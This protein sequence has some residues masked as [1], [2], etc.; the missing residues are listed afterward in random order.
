MRCVR[1][2]TRTCAYKIPSG[3][4]NCTNMQQR[5]LRIN[6]RKQQAKKPIGWGWSDCITASAPMKKR[7][8]NCFKMAEEM[9]RYRLINR[10]R[11]LVNDANVYPLERD[12][13][14]LWRDMYAARLT[15]MSGNLDFAAKTYDAIGGTRGPIE[16]CEDTHT[17][18]S[19]NLAD[20]TIFQQDG[21]QRLLAAHEN[22]SSFFQ[23][24]ILPN[25]D[26][27]TLGLKVLSSTW[28]SRQST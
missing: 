9:T 17:V 4:A 24:R 21:F 8:L 26:S 1:L 6:W 28:R 23:T 2:W 14:R 15:D 22:V 18:I 13:S 7:A 5:I 16:S 11:A 25:I 3:I 20:E 10:L 19:R 27:P 12:N